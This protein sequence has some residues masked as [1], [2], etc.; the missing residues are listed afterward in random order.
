MVDTKGS[1]GRVRGGEL[2]RGDREEERR[3]GGDK[4]RVLSGAVSW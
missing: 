1:W 4:A 2:G 3:G